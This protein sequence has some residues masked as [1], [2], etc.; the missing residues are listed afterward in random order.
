MQDEHLVTAHVQS[1]PRLLVMTGSKRADYA[2]HLVAAV[3]IFLMQDVTRLISV[4]GRR[5]LRSW[6]LPCLRL[7]M[8]L[9]LQ[10]PKCSW[11]LPFLR[12]RM[13]VTRNAHVTGVIVTSVTAL[14]KTK[15]HEVK[16]KTSGSS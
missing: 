15:G 1:V 2:K 11:E 6:A 5:I 10:P 14:L 8:L 9:R 13:V 4:L 12:L 7:D 3:P 16:Q